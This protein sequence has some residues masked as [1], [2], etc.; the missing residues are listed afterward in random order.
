MAVW[1]LPVD[2]LAL[3]CRGAECNVL[4]LAMWL[5]CG[6]SPGAG[7]ARAGGAGP[8]PCPVAAPGRSR[9]LRRFSA[10][11]VVMIQP[12]NCPEDVQQF[13]Q[14]LRLDPDRRFVLKPTE[15]GRSCWNAAALWLGAG[16]ELRFSFAAGAGR[17]WWMQSIVCLTAR[18]S[19]SLPAL[20][21]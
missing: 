8:R 18:G 5:S 17:G 19:P 12:Q 4:M 14:L 10:G 2:Q 13:C 15:P 11:D 3:P 7:A 21:R 20:C 6:L 1:P 16:L 9:C